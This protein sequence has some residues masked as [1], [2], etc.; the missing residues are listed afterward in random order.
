MTEITNYITND[1]KAIDSQETIA[2]VQ[3]FFNELHFSHFPVVEEGIYIGTIASDDLETFDSNKKVI[4]YRYTLEG[5]YTRTNT[6]WLD[7]LEIFAKNHT[8]LV[9]V[10]DENNKYV[11]YYEIEDIMKFF[12][13]TPFLKEP[14]GIIVV[15][16]PI[17]DYSMSQITQIVES[18][19]GKLL[20][21]F[22]SEADVDSVQ[23][24]MKISLG[25]MNEIIQTFRRYNYEIIS[26]HQEDNYINNL[27]E[28]SD[29]LDKY[30][31]I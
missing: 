1:F 22:I 14:G 15:K 21:L 13:E 9:P 31:N 19:N 7:V 17:L 3:D 20:G 30:L 16:K 27:K 24:T 29:Y 5:F 10:L 23:V 6:I 11:G 26:E 28:R 4:D 8:N 2:V 25:A 18:N 12:H